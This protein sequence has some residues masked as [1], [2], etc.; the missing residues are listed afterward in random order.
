MLTI[1]LNKY[2]R[3]LIQADL[4]T[5]IESRAI[6]GQLKDFY[7]CVIWM[8][9]SVCVYLESRGYN[10]F[11]LASRNWSLE[12]YSLEDVQNKV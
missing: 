7:W 10:C 8:C 4:N 6:I 9:A 2:S 5:I 11:L 12:N 3:Y 1:W